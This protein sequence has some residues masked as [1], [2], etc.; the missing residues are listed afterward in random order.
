LHNKSIVFA[1][2]YDK[3][4]VEHRFQISKVQTLLCYVKDL[5]FCWSLCNITFMGR[6]WPMPNRTV[7]NTCNNCRTDIEFV[8]KMGCCMNWLLKVY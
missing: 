6:V 1:P 3:C 5:S 2:S 7:D 8:N 4:M